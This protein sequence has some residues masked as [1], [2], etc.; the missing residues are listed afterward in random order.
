MTTMEHPQRIR[1][2]VTGGDGLIGGVLK[3]GLSRRFEPRWLTRAEADI[4]ELTALEQAFD[5]TDAVVHRAATPDV[6][7]TWKEVLPPNVIGAYNAYEAARRAGVGRFVFAS[8][9]H[10]VGGYMYDDAVFLDPQQPMQIGAD[11]PVRPDSLYG[12]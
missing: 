1:V 3:A 5:G 9:N 8:S 2:A 7:A 11:L 10:A 12:A 6:E 4:T